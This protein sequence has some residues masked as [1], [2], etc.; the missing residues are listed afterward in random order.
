LSGI[1]GGFSSEKVPKTGFGTESHGFCVFNHIVLAEKLPDAYSTNIPVFPDCIV[2]SLVYL[3]IG[4]CLSVAKNRRNMY[5]KTH[6]LVRK[7]GY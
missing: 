3:K 5:V 4:W 6:E 7:E 1:S 2:L